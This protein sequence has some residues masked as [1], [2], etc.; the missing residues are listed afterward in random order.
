M[1]FRML[2]T[3]N[4]RFKRVPRIYYEMF[5]RLTFFESRTVDNRFIR[6]DV[7]DRAAVRA[8]ICQM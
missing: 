6:S 2:K 5:T 3:K 4:L 7:S 1:I 8:A